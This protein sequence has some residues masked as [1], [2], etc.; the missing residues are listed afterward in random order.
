[1]INCDMGESYGRWTLGNDELIMPHIDMANIA[2]GF[3]AGDP[4]VIRRT[5]ELAAKHKVK[6]AA[7]PSYPDQQG[8]GR[9]SMKMAANELKDMLCYQIAAVSGMARFHGSEVT[10]VKPHG[11]LYNDMMAS[12]EL[13]QT[14]IETIAALG[15]DFILVLQGTSQWQ[16]HHSLATKH[17]ISLCFEAFSDRGYQDNGLLV[18]RSEPGALL[19][20]DAAIGQSMAMLQHQQ[21]TTNTG[22]VLPLHIDTLCIHGDGEHAVEIAKK[23]SEFKRKL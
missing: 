18:P 15:S 21:V 6:L 19:D 4:S 22:Q 10:H 11:A 1:M 23:L 3:H 7:H 5:I 17:G 13:M 2:C 8:F 20:K 16:T 14:V 9:R 12:A